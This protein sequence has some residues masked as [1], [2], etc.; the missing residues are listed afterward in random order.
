MVIVAAFFLLL[1]PTVC[2]ARLCL[3]CARLVH[4][5]ECSAVPQCIIAEKEASVVVGFNPGAARL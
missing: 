5:P 2:A 3:N 1:P 4:Q